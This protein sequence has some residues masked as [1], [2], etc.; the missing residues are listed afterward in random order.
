MSLKCSGLRERRGVV[1]PC[2]RN[3]KPDKHDAFCSDMH[4][5][6]ALLYVG[7]DAYDKHVDHFNT[8]RASGNKA[9]I[10]AYNTTARPMF[11]SMQEAQKK[12]VEAHYMNTVCAEYAKGVQCAWNGVDADASNSV[13][14]VM[15]ELSVVHEKKQFLAKRKSTDV[16][17]GVLFGRASGSV[18]AL[19][20]DVSSRTS[21][22]SS[23]KSRTSSA[24]D[25]L[26]YAVEEPIEVQVVHIERHVVSVEEASKMPLPPDDSDDD[27]ME[28]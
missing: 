17:A 3:A 5:K 12:K 1:V 25:L 10:N 9:L 28:E 13:D 22:F 14:A 18:L 6:D 23:K 19:E 8:I 7:Q 4:R 16:L 21:S 26:E 24:V 27:W 20:H 2:G 11:V 15:Q